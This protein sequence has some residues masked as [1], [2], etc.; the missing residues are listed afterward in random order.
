VV[1]RGTAIAAH[2][3]PA[4]NSRCR[5]SSVTDSATMFFTDVDGHHDPRR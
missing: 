4:L 3:T 2:E 1:N 5:C